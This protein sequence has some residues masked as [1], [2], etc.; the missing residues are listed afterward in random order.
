MPP[1]P[2]P[3]GGRVPRR[4]K[5]AP[6]GTGTTGTSDTA[7]RRGGAGSGARDQEPSA[8]GQAR[9]GPTPKLQKSLEELFSAPALAYSLA[10]D[11]WAA[12][13][14]T[15]SAP[16]VAEAWYKLAQE[17]APVRR[18]LERMT[19]G[20]AWGA[21]I[22]STGGMVL[23]LLAH[24]DLLPAQ[25]GAALGGGEP[26]GGPI[27]PPPPA[28]QGPPPGASQRAGGGAA[29]NGSGMTPPLRDDQPPGV[30][31]VAGTGAVIT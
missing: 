16:G 5:E 3:P 31:T 27:V 2:T 23:P 11:E 9:K 14:I 28:P 25:I 26:N 29:S 19:T 12:K 6:S 21:V 4:K 20:S 24:H 10:G 18:V 8:K 13:H 1:V 22:F 30:V 17:S 7:P 15:T